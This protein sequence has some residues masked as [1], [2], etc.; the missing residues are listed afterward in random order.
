[1][2]DPYAAPGPPALD[3]ATAAPHKRLFID[4]C[5]HANV[6][7]RTSHCLLDELDPSSVR[8]QQRTWSAVFS[9]FRNHRGNMD[10]LCPHPATGP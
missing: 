1:M 3:L 10:A 9:T 7:G 4:G 2:A 5:A 6:E 8:K